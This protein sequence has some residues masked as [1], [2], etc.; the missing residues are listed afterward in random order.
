MGDL[1]RSPQN[2]G[3]TQC[4]S[5]TL[6]FP[7]GHI[8][9]NRGDY[10][11]LVKIFEDIAIQGRCLLVCGDGYVSGD[12]LQLQVG[13]PIFLVQGVPFPMVLHRLRATELEHGRSHL[14]VGEAL[15]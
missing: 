5:I 9:K 8:Y 10:D 1:S 11:L 2:N 3:R 12:P 15:V 7:G 13:D 14:I 6:S 4:S